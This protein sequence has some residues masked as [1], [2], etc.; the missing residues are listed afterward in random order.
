MPEYL[1]ELYVSREDAD[2][3]G[4]WGRT[5]RSAVTQLTGQGICVHYCGTIFVPAEETCFAL[6]EADSA[7]AVREVARLAS[8]PFDHVSPAFS[9]P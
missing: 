1:L 8:L 3:A 2:A 6:F 9:Q 7:D 4:E 5:M